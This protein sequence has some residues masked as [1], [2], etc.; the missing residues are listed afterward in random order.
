MK[1]P[2]K[3]LKKVRA[4]PSAA[5]RKPPKGS[6]P[7]SRPP[8]KP[9]V[10]KRGPKKPP[11]RPRKVKKLP[12]PVRKPKKR[13]S[14]SPGP[15][16]GV[17]KF[18]AHAK[19]K[20]TVKKRKFQPSPKVKSFAKKRPKK[21]LPLPSP[22]TRKPKKTPRGSKKPPKPPK[23][24]KKKGERER[25]HVYPI[26][27]AAAELLQ[28]GGERAGHSTAI[29]DK[30]Y[31][32]GTVDVQVQFANWPKPG[33]GRIYNSYLQ[34]RT[35]TS[36]AAQEYMTGALEPFSSVRVNMVWYLKDGSV[37]KYFKLAT[38]EIAPVTT[39]WSRPRN[40][41]AMTISSQNRTAKVCDDA[42][43]TVALIVVNL[44]H[45]A[46]GIWNEAP[47]EFRKRRSKKSRNEAEKLRRE[48]L[49]RIRH[50]NERL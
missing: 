42:R 49:S 21:K 28:A 34:W 24:V 35:E 10:G 19:P 38:G 20:L 22:E 2:P 25:R 12:I 36:H 13:P 26:M 7:V 48:K 37:A 14:P 43:W 32:D 47:E 17:A 46:E 31:A 15:A 11:P 18:N 27:M 4:K 3:K 29:L 30:E 41:T 5:G 1:K 8:P 50:R 9:R 23:K 6:R 44:R 40:Y 45:D 16:K 33:N 39:Y